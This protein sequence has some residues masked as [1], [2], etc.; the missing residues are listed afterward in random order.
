MAYYGCACGW[1]PR[2]LSIHNGVSTEAALRFHSSFFVFYFIAVFVFVVTLVV[3]FFFS[4]FFLSC[5]SPAPAENSDFLF[6]S[7]PFQ[8]KLA[9]DQWLRFYLLFDDFRPDDITWSQL[10]SHYPVTNLCSACAKIIADSVTILYDRLDYSVTN[11]CSIHTKI[12]T[13]SII[14]YC[15]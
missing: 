12:K 5:C 1:L 7:I 2:L 8:C 9:C 4:L 3:F 10:S 6:S 13:N 14:I 11:V 15:V